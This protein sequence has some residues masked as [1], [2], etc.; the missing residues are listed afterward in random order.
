M[1][2][3]KK[4]T[5]KA[6]WLEETDEWGE[7]RVVS[8]AV[9]AKVAE[10]NAK[11]I[12][13][14]LMAGRAEAWRVRNMEAKARVEQEERKKQAEESRIKLEREAEEERMRPEREAEEAR[15]RL[16]RQEQEERSRREWEAEKERIKR[17][18]SE[19]ERAELEEVLGSSW[20]T[21]ASI[22]GKQK[23]KKE[24]PRIRK[25]KAKRIA[26]EEQ[27]AKEE[28][29]AEEEKQKMQAEKEKREREARASSIW[30]KLEEKLAE[31]E[32]ETRLGEIVGGGGEGET[33]GRLVDQ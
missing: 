9:K 20:L 29:E 28:K 21:L 26:K 27:K 13:R 3:P 19:V 10:L 1:K 30:Y 11:E 5:S 32:R 18:W 6:I 33:I 15:V 12:E 25:E 16:E 23:L 4:S 31:K 2:S 17:E 7:K 8:A 24:L 22:L 14:R